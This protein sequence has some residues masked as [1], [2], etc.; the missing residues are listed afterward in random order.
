MCSS[1]LW[2]VNKNNKLGNTWPKQLVKK[3]RDY[4]LLGDS[5]VQ[6]MREAKMYI[7][8]VKMLGLAKSGRRI[9]DVKVVFLNFAKKP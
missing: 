1:D 7:G 2:L 9:K 5:I 3:G 6:P 4:L 8:D